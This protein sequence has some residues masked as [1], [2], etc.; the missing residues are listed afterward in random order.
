MDT[1][2]DT[3]VVVY[4]YSFIS[5]PLDKN[6]IKGDS[7]P[8]T[9]SLDWVSPP[10][11]SGMRTS[12]DQKHKTD[13]TIVSNLIDLTRLDYLFI[14]IRFIKNVIVLQIKRNF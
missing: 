12:F 6:R 10:Q 2:F 9:F 14:E 3:F 13:K 5:D 4:V 8:P 1:Q 7:Q 11:V